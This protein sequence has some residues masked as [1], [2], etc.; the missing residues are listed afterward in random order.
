MPDHAC[1]VLRG[2]VDV[3]SIE[4][5]PAK[6][7]ITVKS[8]QMHTAKQIRRALA[9]LGYRA[10]SALEILGAEVTSGRPLRYGRL[11][12]RIMKMRRRHPRLTRIPPAL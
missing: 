3:L 11:K 10:L 6:R 5:K 8:T 9:R 1:C 2:V 4:L 7:K 12:A